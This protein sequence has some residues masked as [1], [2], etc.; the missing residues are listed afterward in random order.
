MNA[1]VLIGEAFTLGAI[2]MDL[3]ADTKEQALDS[4]VQSAI[5]AKLLPRTRRQQVLDMLLERE[6]RGSTAF[7]RGVAVPHAR[8]T[9]LKRPAGVVARSLKGIDFRAIDG[10]L[11][12]VFLL[13]I[14][15]ET[16]AEEHLATLR[17]ISSVARK[18][19]FLSFIQQASRPEDVLDVL[20]EFSP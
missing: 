5:G 11:V 4:L 12:H 8:I 13:L 16:R 17:W 3:Q 6:Q 7:G 19:D 2:V 18:P 14:S 10:E 20:R 15:P 1:P 9:G